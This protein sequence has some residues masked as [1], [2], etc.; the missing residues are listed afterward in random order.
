MTLRARLDAFVDR[1]SGEPSQWDA[2]SVGIVAGL[3]ALG[4]GALA[5]AIN[6]LSGQTEWR[7]ELAVVQ[8]SIIG[9]LLAVVVIASETIGWVPV[10]AVCL[11]LVGVVYLVVF[12]RIYTQ[13]PRWPFKRPPA[14][15]PTPADSEGSG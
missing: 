2:A 11:M 3:G 15:S 13:N 10:Y 12:K 1:I 7:V 14:A 6:F 5:I 4:A 8:G 9:G